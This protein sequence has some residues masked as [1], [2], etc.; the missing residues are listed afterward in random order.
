MINLQSIKTKHY[1]EKKKPSKYAEG[2][3]TSCMSRNHSGCA[4]KLQQ[5]VFFFF[6]SPDHISITP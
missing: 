6:Y 4:E 1:A 5:C 3:R 2:I